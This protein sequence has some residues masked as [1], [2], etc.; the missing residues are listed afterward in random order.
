MTEAEA[1][2][3]IKRLPEL[4]RHVAVIM[5]GNGRW[6]Q[7]R[8][9]SRLQGHHEGR[10]AT[11]RLVEAAGEAQVGVLTIYSFSSE[12]W[13]RPRPE[14]EGLMALIEDSLRQELDELDA[15]NVVFTASGRLKELPASLQE[16]IAHAQRRTRDNSGLILNLAVNYGG[17]SEIVD[18]ASAIAHRVAAGNVRPEEVDEALF[19]QHLYSPQL[20]DP[21]LVIRT[22]GDMRLSNFLL[23]EAAYAEL[24]VLPILW[25]DFQKLHF[26]EA[27]LT[28]NSRERRFGRVAPDRAPP[29]TA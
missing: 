12:N 24:C 2:E 15:S 26:F 5:D 11:K 14:V 22:G 1:R 17:R 7:Q 8:G 4:P 20:P 6:A 9:L 25:P 21:D 23:W 13:R 10:K 19:R 18:A 16:G 27:L 28:Y 29:A 3:A